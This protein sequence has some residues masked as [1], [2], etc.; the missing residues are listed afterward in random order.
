MPRSESSR[1][2]FESASISQA[3]GSC[4]ASFSTKS[5][6]GTSSSAPVSY[7][8]VPVCSSRRNC[9]S[10]VSR[11][12]RYVGAASSRS[13]SLKAASLYRP[14]RYTRTTLP[15]SVVIL[16]FD[17]LLFICDMAIWNPT[18]SAERTDT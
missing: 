8:A 15:R 14:F 18:E 4:S 3:S 5:S 10:S 7:T 6:C 12:S 2:R 13:I 9:A 1:K 11:I 16:E 17:T